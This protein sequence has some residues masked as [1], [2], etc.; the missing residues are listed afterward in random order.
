MRRNIRHRGVTLKYVKTVTKPNGK[1]FVYYNQPSR[2]RIRL[3]DLPHNHPEFL[4]AYVAAQ[5][6]AETA[7]K[8][9]RARTG[10]LAAAIEAYIASDAFLALRSTTRAGR[11]PILDTISENYGD[12]T[13]GDLQSRHIQADIDRHSG[14]VANNRLKVWR[15]LCRWAAEAGLIAD[16]VALPVRRKPVPRSDGHIPWSEDEIAQYR[17]HWPIGAMERL[18]FEIIYWTG[19]RAG[20][21]VRLSAGMVDDEGWITFRQSKTG[22]EVSIPWNRELPEWADRI[23]ADMDI[24]KQALD[25]RTE[26]H[27]TFITTVYGTPRSV[28][29][30]SQW[31]SGAA[32]SADLPAERSAHG[33]RKSRA[34]ALAELGA[35]VHQ[36]AAWTGHESLSEVDR[37]SRKADRKRLLSRTEGK[38]KL[39]TGPI[40]FPK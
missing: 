40:Q 5:Q 24:L 28:K 23:A 1:R 26:K 2:P 16:N 15:G 27:L 8:R 9:I 13:V 33:L 35:T 25:A 11:R 6:A 10:S 17:A 31:F 36:I 22:G 3:P 29:S 37:Y 14:H 19:V 20:D 12:A 32:S 18:A 30:F 21:A 4:A 34:I 7:P 39:E 38:Q